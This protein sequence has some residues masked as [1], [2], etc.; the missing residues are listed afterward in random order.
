MGKNEAEVENELKKLELD[1]KTLSENGDDSDIEEMVV[2]DE[3]PKP[4]EKPKR[5]KPKSRAPP[6]TEPSQNS[7]PEHVNP[8]KPIGALVREDTI[9]YPGNNTGVQVI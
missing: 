1:E 3:K 6:P 2:P 5:R 4:V 9:L 7:V 8:P